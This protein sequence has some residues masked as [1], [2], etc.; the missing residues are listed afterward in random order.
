MPLS[1]SEA[2]RT[3]LLRLL[4]TVGDGS[5]TKNMIGNYSGA[6]VQVLIK[7]PDNTIYVLTEFQCQNSDKGSYLQDVFAAFAGPLTNGITIAGYDRLGNITLPLTN[8]GTLKTNDD[9]YH[10]G[11]HAEIHAWSATEASLIASL[12]GSHFGT[13]FQL[14]GN[15]G[16]YL[17]VTLN[18]D[19][20]G[21]VDQTFLAK[22]YVK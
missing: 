21:L 7:P 2:I 8:G 13:G 19:F 14:D 11:Y 9:W 18:D 20:T 10:L 5:G 6:P 4:D 1:S 12:V 17:A 15:K 3:P 16:E 22:G